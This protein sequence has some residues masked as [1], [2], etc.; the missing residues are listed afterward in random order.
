MVDLCQVNLKKQYSSVCLDLKN[1]Y[2]LLKPLN[3]AISLLMHEF[4]I[5]VR[6]SGMDFV[7]SSENEPAQFVVHITDLH[8]RFSQMVYNIFA[9]DGEF[10]ASLDRAI[11]SIVNHR[12]DPKQPPRISERL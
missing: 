4:E 8:E 9:G 3:N 2:I 10:I 5:Y 11:Q 6:K 1:M 12:E 7:A